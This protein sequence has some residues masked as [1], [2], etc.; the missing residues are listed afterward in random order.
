MGLA[1]AGLVTCT[2]GALALVLGHILALLTHPLLDAHTAYGTQLLWPLEP[3]PVMWAT[4]FIIDPL[5][6][7]PLLVAVIATAYRP[8]REWG[9]PLLRAHWR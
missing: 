1:A 7:L 8:A 6:T 4:L 2:R 9:T 3:P 5:F